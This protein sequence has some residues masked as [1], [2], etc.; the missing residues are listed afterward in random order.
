MHI[1]EIEWEIDESIIM[2]ENRVADP[3]CDRK[4][5]VVFVK[6]IVLWPYHNAYL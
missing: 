5:G 4:L 3:E 1:E 2:Y 6:Y